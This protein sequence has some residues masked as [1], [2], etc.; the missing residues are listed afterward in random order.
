MIAQQSLSRVIVLGTGRCGTV[1][2]ITACQHIENFTAGHESRAALLGTDRFAYPHRHIEADNRLAWFLGGLGRALDDS[3]TMY[4]HLTREPA[5]VAASFQRRWNSP[6][7][8]NIIRA[9]GHGIVTQT[10]DWSAD[11]VRRVCEFY[12]RT[13]NDNISEFLAQRRSM[14]L[15]LENL[16]DQ[17]DGFMD[18]IDARGDNAAIQRALATV[19]NAS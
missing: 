5:E 13:V 4:V 1:T 9:F 12:V 19:H 15:Q 14:H 11:D 17:F 3:T 2:F 16:P 6:Y 8:A 10:A 18:A 7:R